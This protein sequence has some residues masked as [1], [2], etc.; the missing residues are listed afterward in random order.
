MTEEL[1]EPL[2]LPGS[3]ELAFFGRDV[4]DKAE[5]SVNR[6]GIALSI[7]QI[8]EKTRKEF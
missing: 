3:F 5:N 2:F 4:E 1:I 7:R 6:C 8:V